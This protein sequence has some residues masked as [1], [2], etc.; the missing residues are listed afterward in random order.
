[1]KRYKGKRDQKVWKWMK[2]LEIIKIKREW[3]RMIKTYQK[4]RCIKI[5]LPYLIQ[6]KLEILLINNHQILRFKTNIKMLDLIKDWCQHKYRKILF[7][8]E[9][10]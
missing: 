10:I 9:R 3:F 2:L 5:L 1:M 7:G 6:I 4:E 8:R